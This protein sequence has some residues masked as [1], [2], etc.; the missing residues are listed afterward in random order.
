[1]ISSVPLS[2]VASDDVTRLLASITEDIERDGFAFRSGSDMRSILRARGLDAWAAFASSWDDLGLDLYMADGGRYRRRR[3]AAFDAFSGTVT[4]K[5]HQPHYQSRDH[6]PLNG[7]IER[8]FEPVSGAVCANGFM[9]GILGISTTI[10]DAA[11]P[12]GEAANWHVEMHQF[13]IEADGAQPGL[14]TPEGAHRDGVDW[15]CVLLVDRRNV[16]RGVT[17]IFDPGGRSLG[18]FTLTDPLDTVFLDDRRV[19]HGVTPITP[20]DSASK[21][22]RDVL[23]LTFRRHDLAPRPTI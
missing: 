4:R 23:V 13:R 19:L 2:E 7:D 1:M 10:F 15:V 20:M 12:D 18:E 14:A 6:N 16:S 9:R 11:S 8:W 5:P 3:F 22:F 21:A 17:Q